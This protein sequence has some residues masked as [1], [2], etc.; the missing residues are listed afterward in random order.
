MKILSF[1]R[2]GRQGAGC[3]QCIHFQNDPAL[4]EAVY[5]ELR[6]MSSGFA[7]VRDRDGFC[8][9]HQLYLSA[10]DVCAEL[11]VKNS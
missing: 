6:T 3:E 1:I 11:E 5:P 4:V 8:Q 9:R 2:V 10:G 7:A